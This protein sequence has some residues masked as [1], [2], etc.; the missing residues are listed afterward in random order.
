VSYLRLI[1]PL[2]V[3]E[4][5]DQTAFSC[6]SMFLFLDFLEQNMLNFLKRSVLLMSY[7]WKVIIVL[8]IQDSQLHFKYLQS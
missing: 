3:G 6:Q 2:A 1:F 5:S 8:S 4:V 7:Y